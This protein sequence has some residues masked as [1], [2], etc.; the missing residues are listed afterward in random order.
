MIRTSESIFDIQ[1]L[2]NNERF[3]DKMLKSRNNRLVL[4]TIENKIGIF[5]KAYLYAL[6]LFDMIFHTESSTF[7]IARAVREQIK[8]VQNSDSATELKLVL[9]N[10]EKINEY[11][12]KSNNAWKFSCFRAQTLEREIELI[13][14][15][16]HI[17]A[18]KPLPLPFPKMEE[19]EKSKFEDVHQIWRSNNEILIGMIQSCDI[20][21]FGF[22]GTDKKGIDG[23]RHTKNP[24]GGYIWVAGI[25]FHLDPI[26]TLADFYSIIRKS[27]NYADDGI[28]VVK[29]G[30]ASFIDK[31]IWLYK[32][33]RYR[34]MDI[35]SPSDLHFLKLVDR[36]GEGESSW[37]RLRWEDCWWEKAGVDISPEM[38]REEWGIKRIIP[39][40]QSRISIP[41]SKIY[42]ADELHL[43]FDPQSY[44]SIVK[45]MIFNEDSLYPEKQVNDWNTTE[46]WKKFVLAKRFKM[47]EILVKAFRFLSVIKETKPEELEKFKGIGKDLMNRAEEV[48]KVSF[49]QLNKDMFT[50]LPFKIN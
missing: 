44:S 23:I 8:S 18:S 17:A 7:P 24:K 14:E 41:T 11:I 1:M 43:S 28:F 37:R 22:H 16:I 48:T 35:D 34:E 42:V 12:H 47:Q 3:D 4:C 15:S 45:G 6:K 25:D 32:G 33:L 31:A 49:E 5:G 21:H 26:S 9:K 10:V 13:K 46:D 29:T 27:S 30:T 39:E 36:N 40:F 38:I 19:I 20:P 2:Y 50:K